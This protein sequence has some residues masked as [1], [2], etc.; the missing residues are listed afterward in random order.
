MALTGE[1]PKKIDQRIRGHQDEGKAGVATIKPG[2]AIELQADGKYDPMVTAQAGA[3]KR[4]L[5]IAKHDILQGKTVDDAYAV[6]ET[7]FFFHALPGDLV[8]VLVKSG[9]DIDFGEK[10]CVEGTTSGLFIAAAGTE[11]KFQ[12]E[13]L[14]DSGGA[15]AADSLM[16]CRVI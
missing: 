10:L 7:V 2:M 6:D 1:R 5:Q 14:E 4:N 11:T 16:F 13:S 15:L 3:L 12:L 8:A 9:E